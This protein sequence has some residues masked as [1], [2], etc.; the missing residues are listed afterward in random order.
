MKLIG[1]IANIIDR[2]SWAYGEWGIVVG[3]NVECDEYFIAI[4]GDKDT[5]LVFGRKDFRIRRK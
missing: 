3:A 5:A 1:K 2:E 4:A